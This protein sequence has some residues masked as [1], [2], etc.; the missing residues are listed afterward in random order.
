METM[1]KA[2]MMLKADLNW[3]VTANPIY[4]N[5]GREL[6]DFK[7]ITRDDT[8]RVFN[9]ARNRYVPFQ[10]DV[11]FNILD[12][13]M[14][15][16]QAKY[17]NAGSFN[18]GAF[19]YGLLAVPSF[20]FTVGKNDLC[21][22]YI[23]FSTSHDGSSAIKV[24]PE[25]WR[26]ICSNGMHAWRKDDARSISVRHT[27]S[28]ESR[29]KIDAE[30]L[31]A[32]EAEYFREYSVKARMLAEKEFSRLQLESFLKTLF[33]IEDQEDIST[34]SLNQM[35]EIAYLSNHGKGIDESNR[36]TAWAV[37]NGVTEFVTHHRGSNAESRQVSAL[38]GS[39][40]ELRQK[41]WELLTV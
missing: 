22:G 40:K 26:Q 13:V 28:A 3:R 17:S 15:T 21:K 20:D 27:Q 33:E 36:G 14:Q 41:A 31:L 8:G 34:R 2:E 38:L 5:Q 35:K 25:V 32:T 4:D 37:Y 12:Q 19:V 24:W 1:T 30:R 29:I 10:N 9:I 18:E 11:L 16:G 39:G 23:R 7:A 6:E